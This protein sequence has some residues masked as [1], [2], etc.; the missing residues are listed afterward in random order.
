MTST[1]TDRY[2][3]AVTR[4]LRE[5]QRAEIER[6]LRASLGDAIEARIEA[7]ADAAAA[8]RDIIVELG[9]PDRLA[10]GYAERP[11]HLIGPTYYLDWW[12]L[13]KLL[14]GIVAPIAFAA[15]LAVNLFTDPADVGGAFGQAFTVAFT[16]IVQLAFWVTVVFAIIERSAGAKAKPLTHWTPDLLPELPEGPRIGIV[17]TV[18]G[19]VGLLFFAAAIVWQHLSSLFLDAAGDPI[20]LLNPDLWSFW[21]PWF[22]GVIVL[23]IVFLL[24]TFARGRHTWLLAGVNVVLGLLFTV[25]AL[26]LLLTGQLINPE[27]VAAAGATPQVMEWIVTGATITVVGFTIWDIIDGFL[28][29]WR[30]HRR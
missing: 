14:V 18:L 21:I 15:L 17:E 1:L 22:L 10:A 20:P 13:L 24:V 6:E 30:S 27:F 28:K 29:A 3:H 9:D 8:E 11:L 16:V 19:T 12:R 2:V 7:G 25:P 4:S 26:W 23:E 5:E